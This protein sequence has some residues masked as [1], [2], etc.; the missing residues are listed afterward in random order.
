MKHNLTV[1]TYWKSF[2]VSCHK[3]VSS[4][5]FLKEKSY[6]K[7]SPLPRP[8]Y[9]ESINNN[10][11]SRHSISQ[12]LM[13]PKQSNNC[14]LVLYSVHRSSIIF[15]SSL[16]KSRLAYFAEQDDNAATK[17]IW[18]QIIYIFRLDWDINTK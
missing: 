4:G 9:L 1:R 2:M 15:F 18:K 6:L 11:I 13:F 17:W 12:L 14:I 3:Y 7:R 16:C 5:G 10:S 8:I